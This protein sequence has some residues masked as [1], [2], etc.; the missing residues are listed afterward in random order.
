MDKKS[1]FYVLLVV[2]AF[3][4]LFVALYFADH[5]TAEDENGVSYPSRFGLIEIKSIHGSNQLL[6][7]PE[8]KIVYMWVH[9]VYTAG[10]S[11]YYVIGQDGKP[12]VAIYGENYWR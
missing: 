3:V 12:E 8:T 11:P 10:I 5:Q 4:G 9:S 2:V 6:Y 1:I 7:D